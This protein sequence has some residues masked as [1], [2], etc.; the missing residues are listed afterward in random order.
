M[1]L[2]RTQLKKSQTFPV[3]SV[4]KEIRLRIPQSCFY[5]NFFLILVIRKNN[6]KTCENIISQL[7]SPT[8]NV[9][10]INQQKLQAIN[11]K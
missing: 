8:H 1:I 9:R 5:F 6:F 7:F 4:S 11:I 10:T 3:D 2:I